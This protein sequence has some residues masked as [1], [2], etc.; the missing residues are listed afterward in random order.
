MQHELLN[1]APGKGQYI[2]IA[3]SAVLVLLG[4]IWT[5]GS[6]QEQLGMALGF[7]GIYGTTVF[8]SA[9]VTAIL[10]FSQ[11]KVTRR[12]TFLCLSIAYSWVALLA[13]FQVVLLADAFSSLSFIS[14]SSTDAAWLWTFWHVGFPVLISIGMLLNGS[15]FVAKRKFKLWSSV[16]LTTAGFIASLIIL[17][18]LFSWWPLPNLIDLSYQYSDMLSVVVGPI[19]ILSCIVALFTVIVKGQFSSSIYSW[20]AVAML[21][22]TCEGIV[23]IYGGSRFSYGWYTARVLS[24]VSSS[25]VAI[26]LVIETI[27]LQHKVIDQNQSLR[28]MASTDELTGLANRRELDERLKEET[29]RSMRER[30]PLSL[31]LLDVDRFKRFN[32]SYGHINGDRCLQHVADCIREAVH[33][34]I[35]LPAR[36][37]GEE[38][39]V[40]L[41]NTE[42]EAA[43]ELAEEIR[44][45]IEETSCNLESGKQVMVT[46]SLGVASLVANH[47][48]ESLE[49]FRIADA[50][51]YRAKDA[52][53][54]RVGRPSDSWNHSR[55]KKEAKIDSNIHFLRHG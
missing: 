52:G 45:V 31:I 40:L 34:Y 24:I 13:P 18:T 30:T 54:N 43:V 11:F 29:L 3:I 21:A 5:V 9:V 46:A 47:A 51:L 37:G 12:L 2:F 20:L 39:A 41:P 10:L 23:T 33:R 16:L 26:A 8:I 19:V 28:K 48:E 35:D 25:A 7:V 44:S 38:F 50:A 4:S 22:A 36:Y 15:K 1:S 27:S 14:A 17:S 42:E 55:Q 32:D 49:L 6:A 53:R